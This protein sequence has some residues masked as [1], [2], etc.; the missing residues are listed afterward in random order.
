MAHASRPDLRG[1]FERALADK[2]A[3]VRYYGLRGIAQIGVG[4]ADQSVDR[5]KR[6]DDVRVR[7]AAQ[8]ALDGRI[9]Q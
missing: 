8:A 5:R 2:D 3:C 7:L 1:L 6:D 9:P 4:R